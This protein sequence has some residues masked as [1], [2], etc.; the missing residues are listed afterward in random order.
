MSTFIMWP[1]HM[2]LLMENIY[3]QY[4]ICT[5]KIMPK[6]KWWIEIHRF[7]HKELKI[8]ICDYNVQWKH[9]KYLRI[10][11]KIKMKCKH[12]EKLFGIGPKC[13]QRTREKGCERNWRRQYFS[14][15]SLVQLHF[16]SIFFWFS[17]FLFSCVYLSVHLFVVSPNA[18]L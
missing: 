18:L 12:I 6:S 9:A 3:I 5:N 7:Y 17:M 2:I 1:H 11:F 8:N 14:L 16:T 10:G 4:I 15:S 13:M